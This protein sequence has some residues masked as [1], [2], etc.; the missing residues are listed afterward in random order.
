MISDRRYA[1]RPGFGL[2]LACLF[3]AGCGGAKPADE[4]DPTVRNA[5]QILGGLSE[6]YTFA[7]TTNKRPPAKLQDIEKFSRAEAFTYPALARG[8][9]VVFWG[10]NIGSGSAILAYEKNAPL[11]GGWVLLQDHTLKQMSAEE[12]KAAPKAGS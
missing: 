12:F 6:I 1:P 10:A 7:Q 4:G 2:L 5:R 11:Q 3:A 8:E 9:V